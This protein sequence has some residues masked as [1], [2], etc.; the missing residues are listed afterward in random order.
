M[1]NNQNNHIKGKFQIEERRRKVASLIAQ[2]MT[3]TE[4]A[5][6]ELSQQFV[7]DLAKSDLAMMKQCSIF[8]TN[9]MTACF[10]LMY[11]KVT[12]IKQANGI[13]ITENYT[14]TY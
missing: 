10:C 3:E 11:L 7:Y 12:K 8:Q 9:I 5:K 1:H 13:V 14:N 2:P 4:I 6:Q